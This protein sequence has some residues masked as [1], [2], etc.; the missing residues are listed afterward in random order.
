MTVPT[1]DAKIT[2]R[3]SY[4]SG[5]APSTVSDTPSVISFPLVFIVTLIL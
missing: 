3:E 1:D 2:R 5:V 4:A